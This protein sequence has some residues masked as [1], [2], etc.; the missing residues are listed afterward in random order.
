MFYD[1]DLLFKIF[2]IMIDQ[3]SSKVNLEIV[4]IITTIILIIIMIIMSNY[5]IPVCCFD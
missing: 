1:T 4:I 2:I 3:F 5:I